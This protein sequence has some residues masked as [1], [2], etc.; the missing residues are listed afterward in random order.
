L[1]RPWPRSSRA[2]PFVA[3]CIALAALAPGAAPQ[4]GSGELPFDNQKGPNQNF[5]R[6][7]LQPME[8]SADGTRLYAINAPGGRLAAFDVASGAHVLDIPIGI[9]AVSLVR[10]PGGEQLWVVDEL[11][12]AVFV[13]QPS[14]ASILRTVRVGGQPHGIAFTPDG[15]RAY[16]TCSGASQVDVIDCASIEVVKSI[17]LPVRQPRGIVW[18][19]G[20]AWV[21]PLL[22]GN[23]SAPRGQPN[24]P[25]H[26]VG[27]SKITAAGLVPLPD[28]DL[29][30]IA[31]EADPTQDHYVPALTRTGL[32]TVLF[33]VVLRPGTSELWIPGTEALNTK[34][35]G[36]ASYVAGQVVSNRITVVDLQ[37]GEPAIHDLDELAP[38]DQRLAQPTHVAFDATG[39]RAY[40]A[41]YGTD[42]IGVFDVLP[43]GNLSW[44]G[45]IFLPSQQEYPQGSGPRQT[46]IDPSAS[47]LV[48]YNRIDNAVTRIALSSL[49]ANVPFTF[50]AD[51]PI[52]LGLNPISDEEQEGRFLFSNARF[53]KSMTSSCASCHVDGHTDG[54]AWDL[55][56][57]LDPE[58]TPPSQLAYP[59]DNKGPMVTQS[60]RRLQETGPYHW[61]GER[62]SVLEFNKAFADLLENQVNGQPAPIESFAYLRHYLNNLRWPA[63]PYAPLNRKYTAKQLAGADVFLHKPVFQGHTCA[64]CHEL[65]LGTSGEI[66][67]GVVDGVT[68]SMDVPPLRGLIEKRAEPLVIGGAFGTRSEL[69]A[70]FTHG[71]ALATLE[72]VLRRDDPAQPGTP[73]FALT[74]LEIDQLEAFLEAFDWGIAPAAGYAA[75]AWTGNLATFP[76]AELAFL[77]EQAELGHCD[78]VYLRVPRIL[79]SGVVYL[80]G[81]YNPKT[82]KYTQA[83]VWAGELSQAEVLS[84]VAQGRPVTFLGLPLGMGRSIGL[85]RDMDE[86]LDLDESRHGT[87]PEEFDS[88]GDSFPDG[89]EVEREM[90]PTVPDASAPDQT[91]PS[92]VGPVRVLWTTTNT[93]KFEL[94]TSE[95]SRV[96]VA[97]N[98]GYPVQRLPLG[99]PIY[100]THHDVVLD[101][102]EPGKTYSLDL[103]FEDPAHNKKLDT[104]TKIQTRALALG[105]PA[106]VHSIGLALSGSNPAE[107]TA[108]VVLRSGK[109]PVGADYN[110]VGA[111]YRVYLSGALELISASA[112]AKTNAYGVAKIEVAL[113]APSQPSTLL[114]VLK[115][116][117]P[118]SGKPGYVQAFNTVSNSGIP[119]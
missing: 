108:S 86:L 89:W 20:H 70:G 50:T 114:F 14:T 65:P 77:Q 67:T 62:K 78:L 111:V 68:R 17:P 24:K 12:S 47:W 22:S 28:R 71:G 91:P 99:P 11:S 80:A 54:L 107:L 94:D 43:G 96:Q 41:G 15:D 102:L 59:L 46:L 45:S 16:V 97:Y 79:P 33:N 38:S 93:V 100:A 35:K 1:L 92:L 44:A 88:D 73:L 8:L 61:R 53:S 84:D 40:V 105:E 116:V 57:F 10:R 106:R 119:Y 9:G 83:T 49:P 7:P 26:I 76:Q 101:G 29:L 19:D 51:K 69:G 110:V 13:V 18:A 95:M 75:T 52:D 63:N 115:D 48:S 60:V 103:E 58:P 113:P 3:A 104:S 90:D 87:D 27:V 56:V 82:K 32:G 112:S 25:N 21:V 37:G 31:T 118:P 85:D 74:P 23:N 34:F 6:S 98:G 2:L 39:N 109:S 64:D 42:L 30:A 36:E 66:A 81:E 72:D 117:K 5:E 4:V 55:S